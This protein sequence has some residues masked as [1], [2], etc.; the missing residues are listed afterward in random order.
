MK[1]AFEKR[2]SEKAR[3]ATYPF[4]EYI[5]GHDFH[6]P[7]HAKDICIDLVEFKI[8]PVD[9]RDM[10]AFL[11]LTGEEAGSDGRGYYWC[12]E[13]EHLNPTLQHIRSRKEWLGAIEKAVLLT[14]NRMRMNA[15][16]QRTML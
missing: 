13:A 11:Q 10:R 12:L 3:I 15:P 14:Q 5:H 1:T 9:I 6:H 4:L 2:M 8:S 7:I 16:L